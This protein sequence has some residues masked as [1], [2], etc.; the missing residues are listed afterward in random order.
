MIDDL[1]HKSY[2]AVFNTILFYVYGKILPPIRTFCGF[3]SVFLDL[4]FPFFFLLKKFSIMTMKCF[5][6]LGYLCS[7]V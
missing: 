6:H 7:L 4:F 3:C 5:I 1:E 2:K